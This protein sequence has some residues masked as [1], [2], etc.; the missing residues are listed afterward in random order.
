MRARLRRAVPASLVVYAFTALCAL[1]AALPLATRVGTPAETEPQTTELL[2]VAVRLYYAAA[3]Q[4][5]VAPLL[6]TL[7][8]APLL[9]SLWLRSLLR[10]G[11]LPEHSAAALR[12]YRAALAACAGSAA[13]LV[14]AAAL[15]CLAGSAVWLLLGLTGNVAL[16]ALGASAVVVPGLIAC[17]L[18]AP[19]L[20]DLALLQLARGET[21][22]GAA[23]FVG[24][25]WIDGRLLRA[26]AALAAVELTLTAA[27]LGLRSWLGSSPRVTTT[28]LLVGQLLMLGAIGARAV[29]LAFLVEQTAPHDT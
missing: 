17:A 11:R 29:W 3:A 9:R 20:A 23:L 7:L 10:R 24:W 8:G 18:V 1:A 25:A 22:P 13:W 5:G 16:Q 27:A 12:G 2:L 15:V 26:R 21:Q 4:L 19:T 6:L 14:L 28:D